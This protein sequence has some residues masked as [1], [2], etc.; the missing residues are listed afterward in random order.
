MEEPKVG[1]DATDRFLAGVLGPMGDLARDAAALVRSVLPDAYETCE[2]GDCGFGTAP[3]Y[4]GLVFTLTPQPDHITL[5]FANGAGLSDPTGLLEGRGKGH[6][7]VRL[8]SLADLRRGALNK[9]LR[10]AVARRPP[11]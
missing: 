6:R 7:H 9:L 8:D 3:G 10:E 2:G 4:K 11:R 5:G 1:H